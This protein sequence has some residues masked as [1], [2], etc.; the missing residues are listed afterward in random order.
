MAETETTEHVGVDLFRDAAGI[1]SLIADYEKEVDTVVGEPEEV[2]IT[3]LGTSKPV[4]SQQ[5]TSVQ[6]KP[7]VVSLEEQVAT[8][9]D[10][11]PKPTLST[12]D[13]HSQ[14]LDEQAEALQQQL[15]RAKQLH[16]QTTT[17]ASIETTPVDSD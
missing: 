6:Q 8:A 4:Q 15:S 1:L 16:S 9:Q 7:A 2:A 10:Q 12:S 3:S 14:D 5:A 17:A 13:E 11:P